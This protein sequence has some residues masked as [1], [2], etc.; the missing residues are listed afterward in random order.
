MR[1]SDKKRF[2]GTIKNNTAYLEIGKVP[3]VLLIQ[4]DVIDCR[5]LSV[6]L[7]SI[8]VKSSQRQTR[9]RTEISIFTV[10]IFSFRE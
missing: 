4:G 7:A 9:R 3:R 5:L 1:K 8:D 6:P 10:A 2:E